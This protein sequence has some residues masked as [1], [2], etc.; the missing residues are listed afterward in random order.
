MTSPLDLSGLLCFWDF[1]GDSQQALTARGPHPYRLLEKDGAAAWHPEGV[2][3]AQSV[4][5]DGRTWLCLP[6]RDC[7]AL[8]LHGAQAQVSLVAWVKRAPSLE[9]QPGCEAVAGMWNEHGK[10]Q[11]ALFLNL[12]IH[13]SA[14]QV[15]AHISAVGGPTPGYK[16]CMDAAI[17]VTPVRRGDWHVIGMTY[18]SAYARAY[19]DGRLDTRGARNPYA[20]PGG[21]YNAGPGGADFTVGAVARP[22]YVDELFIEHGNVIANRYYGLLGGL[23]VF[24]RALSED[25]MARLTV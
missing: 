22:A 3:G 4:C 14:E 19:L 11:Y 5:F 10:R 20:Y 6:R 21:I 7:P 18:D 8:D 2:F 12:Q 1:Q 23:A 15:G 17:G 25:E 13:N 24:E 16:Y 9:P